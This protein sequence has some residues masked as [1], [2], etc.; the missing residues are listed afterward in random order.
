MDLD[1][2]YDIAQDKQIYSQWDSTSKPNEKEPYTLILP[3][4]NITGILH[5]GHAL[6]CTIQDI[7]IRWKKLNGYNTLWIPGTDHAG[8]ATQY[9]IEK[10]L[11]AEGKTKHDLGREEFLKRTWEWKQ[12][13]GSTILNQLKEIGCL[14]DW[15][16]ERFTM[17][18]QY[19]EFMTAAFIKLSEAGYI[20]RGYRMI[21]YCPRCQTSLSEDEITKKD[22]KGQLHLLKYKIPGTDEHL[23]IATSRPET[24]FGDTAIGLNPNDPRADKYKGKMVSIPLIGRKIPIILDE[25][26]DMKFGT[27]VLKITPGHDF[28]DYDLGQKHQLPLLTIL[29]QSGKICG[30]GT[31][32][33]GYD[34]YACRKL[35]LADLKTQG[36]Y[37]GSIE[38]NKQSRHCYRCAT[39]IEPSHSQQWFLSM[40]ELAQRALD[41]QDELNF[42]PDYQRKI[43]IQWLTNIKD[44][45][46]GRQLW[47]GHRIPAY[48]CAD[49][50]HIT[51]GTKITSCSKCSSGKVEQ[52]SDSLDTWFS[53]WCWPFAIFKNP[54]DLKYYYPIDTIISGS[55]ILF[56]WITR[57]IMASLFFTDKLPFKNIY[58]H[59]LIRDENNEKMSKSKGNA[60]DPLSIVSQI[61]ADA[62]RYTIISKTKTSVGQDIKLGMN[63]F[64]TG[65]LFRTKLWNGAKY[66]IL[67]RT[68]QAFTKL[69]LI[70]NPTQ[71]NCWITSRLHQTIININKALETYQFW[72]YAEHLY[73]FIWTDFCSFYL[74]IT[75]YYSDAL[76]LST[77]NSTFQSILL[78]A[79]P[80]MPFVTEKLHRALFDAPLL[81]Q[82]SWPLADPSLIDS[83]LEQ[84]ITR[85]QLLITDLRR[86]SSLL[87]S[88]AFPPSYLS[89]EIDYI[90]KL[91][92]IPILS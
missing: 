78:L 65:K 26:I 29:D 70:D 47:W 66:I 63:D 19:Q 92:K 24:L 21:N 7:L 34:R 43:Y 37:E 10:Q 80:L 31:Q 13:S 2:Y 86:C 76:T 22:G 18:A 45:C 51:I 60:I 67:R 72:T 32:Y 55:D 41:A 28:N 82:Q 68:G 46:I 15:S 69:P 27:G 35:L 1:K 48:H 33:D 59:Q 74:E 56:F 44:W 38:Y 90:A 81:N 25:T 87:T 54:E 77:L 64:D 4:P 20:Y 3:P 40:K 30:T 61:G 73:N 53:S 5:M 52:D 17:D 83:A 62:L 8:I 14:C 50:Q 58:L 11:L 75:K 42:F 6:N 79:H 23:T 85:I 91:T 84:Q 16:R 89:S 88:F 12:K 57:M 49:C 71:I 36:L 39:E 9:V